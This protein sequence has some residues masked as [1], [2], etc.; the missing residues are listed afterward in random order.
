MAETTAPS[1]CE[2]LNVNLYLQ[3][4]YQYRKN[5]AA[6]FSYEMWAHAMNVPSRSYLRF[7]ILGKR[8]ISEELAE[9]IVTFINFNE[10]EKE[11]FFLLV[12]YTQA[13]QPESKRI[14]GKRLTHIL[15]SQ[16]PLPEISPNP[17]LLTHPLYLTVRN[18]LSFSDAPRNAEGLARILNIPALQ[19]SEILFELQSQGFVT[20]EEGGWIASH[21]DVK[22]AD[23]PKNEA[24]RNYHK[25]TLLKAIE[26]QQ[27]PVEERSYRSIGL[28]LSEE[29]YHSYLQDLDNFAKEIYARYRKDTLSNRRL[30]Q[31]NF[32]LFP[33]TSVVPE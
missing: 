30:Y 25:L 20:H 11:Y 32:N 18:I 12:L 29:E 6:G 26:A 27:I 31:I 24:M 14:Y 22:I 21:S 3:D 16:I 1:L 7:A 28:P 15:R 19:I 23:T 17:S 33:W 9:K 4:Y 10:T 13:S 2:Y 8:G 5:L